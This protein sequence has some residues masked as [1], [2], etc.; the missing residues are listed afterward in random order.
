VVKGY[1]DDKL[2]ERLSRAASAKSATLEKFRAKAD[3]DDPGEIQRRAARKEIAR[4]RDLR[5]AERKS[6]RSAKDASE[7]IER[8]NRE[9]AEL[10]QR[11]EQEKK[12]ASKGELHRAKSKADRDARYA[13]RKQRKKS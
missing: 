8:A 9:A 3:A 12:D 2:S 1:K 10:A 7:A 6:A 13:S 4:A 11:I 5:T